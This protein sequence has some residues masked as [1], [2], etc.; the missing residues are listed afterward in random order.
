MFFLTEMKIPLYPSKNI[1]LVHI[2]KI[3][4]LSKCAFCLDK[5]MKSHLKCHYHLLNMIWQLSNCLVVHN[6]YNNANI[7]IT[8]DLHYWEHS[9]CWRDSSKWKSGSMQQWFMGHSV[10]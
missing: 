9:S 8:S 5:V 1:C 7:Y 10:R 3:I 6:K 2:E 4:V